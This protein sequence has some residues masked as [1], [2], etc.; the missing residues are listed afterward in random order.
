MT[1]SSSQE[2]SETASQ[3][4][5]K[6]GAFPFFFALFDDFL[7]Q[8]NDV[9]LSLTGPNMQE[10]LSYKSILHAAGIIKDN[11]DMTK[12]EVIQKLRA[13]A[14]PSCMSKLEKNVNLAVQA[15]LM[16][17]CT[18]N[19]WHATDFTLGNHRPISWLSQEKYVDFFERS[20]PAG[21][22]S[23]LNKIQAAIED[24]ASMKAWKLQKRLGISFRGTNNLA[25]H[26]LFDPRRNCLYLFHHA[27][28]LK[29][30]LERYQSHDRPL[31]MTALESLNLGT[32]PA[33][34]LVETLHSLQSLLFPPIDQKS[35]AILDRLMTKRNENFDCECAEYEGYKIFQEPPESFQYVYW[36]ERLVHL[37]E[38]LKTRPPR[39][40]LERWLKWQ[41]SEGNALF[42]ALL[43]LLIS[44]CVGAVSVGIG[45]VQVWIAWMA[46]KHPVAPG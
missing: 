32:V 43:A 33:Q 26:L 6:A 36:G 3:L 41:S 10:Q 39:N 22:Q 20:F 15:M 45:A 27:E 2:R 14:A 28:F 30:H 25:E 11:P 24:K 46:W 1:R 8:E 31:E 16:V 9:A 12:E 21:H 17:D 34:L 40:R 18:A 7:S 35:A 44:I 37:Q 5:G 4:F 13:T 23:S 19:H 29:A 38:L 42:V